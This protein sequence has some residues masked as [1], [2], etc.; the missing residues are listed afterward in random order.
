MHFFFVVLI[1][2]VRGGSDKLIWPIKTSP[3]CYF[4]RF[5][6]HNFLSL[7]LIFWFKRDSYCNSIFTCSSSL[8]SN[9]KSFLFTHS[10]H[11]LLLFIII[12]TISIILFS[13]I[14]ELRRVRESRIDHC[15]LGGECTTHHRIIRRRHFSDKK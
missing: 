12:T 11:L 1:D 7:L 2:K 13:L 5:K 14:N 4:H 3:C 9:K 10:N 15:K 8:P 6:F